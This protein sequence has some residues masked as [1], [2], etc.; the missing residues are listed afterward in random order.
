MP[1]FSANAKQNQNQSHLVRAIFSRPFN[2]L[3]VI[4]RN[5]DW[6]IALFVPVGIDYFGIGFST[7]I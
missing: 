5:S 1:G 6:L 3:Q 2:K 7:V 4:A